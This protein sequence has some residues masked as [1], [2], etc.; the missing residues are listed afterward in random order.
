MA[1]A[2]LINGVVNAVASRDSIVI[3]DNFQSI[4]GGRTLD[5]TGFAS[6]Q[7]EAGH[8]I[9]KDATGENY[10]PMPV[11]TGGTAY[12][13]LPA[14]HT[15][16]GILVATIRK[17]KPFAG[18]MVR[19]TVNENAAKFAYTEAMKTALSLVVFTHDQA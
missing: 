19:G 3:V 10:K 16:E 7:I 6:D 1:V 14:D 11:N 4:R 9:I 17:D 2:N 8:V 12:D 13:I 18:I 5:V 15:I